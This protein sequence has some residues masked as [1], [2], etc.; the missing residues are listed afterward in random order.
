MNKFILMDMLQW[1]GKKLLHLAML[2]AAAIIITYTL[3]NL[4]PI[5]PVQSYIGADTMRVGPEQREAI[6]AYWGL[7]K[8][9]LERFGKWAG[10]LMQG[11]FGTSMIYRDKV[12][13]VIADRFANSI[14][15]M[16]LAWVMSGLIGFA[17][18]SLA[19][20]NKGRWLDRFITGVC[21]TL[22]SAPTFWV[23]LLLLMI[24]SVWLGWF[25][26]GLAVPAGMLS[27][28]VTLW[29]KLYHI[30]LPA[31]TLSIV[32]IAPIA[33]HSRQKLLDVLA[34]DYILFAR[35]RGERGFHLFARQ[36]LRNAALP[37]ITLQFASFGELFGGAVLA[38]QIFSYPGL[39]QATI[40]SAL[41]G[42]I[43]LL[44]GLVL[45][46][47]I[48]VFVGNALADAINRAVDPRMRRKREGAR[49]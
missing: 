3:V 44:M 42:D 21:Y 41:R 37:A 6:A 26:I 8:P 32:G 39:G 19:A 25:P 43:P 46:S 29:D 22:A 24:F 31:I 33:L 28:D 18:G 9:P 49:Q 23:G 10:A 2:L 36:A 34:S 14:T 7:D 27:A 17:A 5:D 47:T 16:A 20:M 11:D 30:F 40:E 12:D 13:H 45:F 35:A 15:L 48:F 4:S 1:A 38:E